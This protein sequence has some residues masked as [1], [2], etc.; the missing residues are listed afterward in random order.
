LAFGALPLAIHM[1]LR[2]CREA[3]GPAFNRILAQTA[4]V[5]LAFGV[6][7]CLGLVL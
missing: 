5:Q 6:L 2:F 4:Q 3:P 1:I 7:L